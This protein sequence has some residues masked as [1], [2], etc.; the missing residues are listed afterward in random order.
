[1][2]F[3]DHDIFRVQNDIF[4]V[5]HRAERESSY[6]TL[7]RARR[8]FKP[9]KTQSFFKSILC[10]ANWNF[11]KGFGKKG[12]VFIPENLSLYFIKFIKKISL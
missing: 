8:A 4:R 2:I 3:A 6:V 11:I 9:Q 5:K 12:Y 1:M 7:Y 10:P